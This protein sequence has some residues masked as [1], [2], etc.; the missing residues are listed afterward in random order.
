MSPEVM[1][2]VCVAYVCVS[3]LNEIISPRFPKRDLK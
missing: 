1:E 3:R 2:E